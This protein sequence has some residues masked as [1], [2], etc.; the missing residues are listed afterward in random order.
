ML[1]VFISLQFGCANT[2]EVKFRNKIEKMS[3]DELVGYYHGLNDRLKDLDVARDENPDHISVPDSG[4][5]SESISEYGAVPDPGY[6]LF[7]KIQWSLAELKK[8][9]IKP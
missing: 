3:D 6:I 9:K 2:S 8:R 4:H 1:L 5:Y 7:K